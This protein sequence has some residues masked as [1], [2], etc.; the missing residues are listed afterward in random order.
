[1]KTTVTQQ[2]KVAPIVFTLV[3]AVFLIAN[4]V[5][6]FRVSV[7]IDKVFPIAVVGLTLLGT[8]LLLLRSSLVPPDHL[9]VADHEMIGEDAGAPRSVW[10]ALGWLVGL[11]AL[12]GLFGFVIALVLFFVMFLRIRAACGWWKISLL[13]AAALCGLLVIAGVL[14]RDFPPGLLQ[15]LFDL[16]WP[17]R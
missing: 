3:I 4:L 7:L 17:F 10:S 6:S 15:E 2:S 5:D 11:L 8:L 13:T 16:P 14:H 1:V 12:T 9:V